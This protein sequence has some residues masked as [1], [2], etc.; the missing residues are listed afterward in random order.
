MTERFLKL[1]Y[2]SRDFLLLKNCCLL[3]TN[4]RLGCLQDIAFEKTGC[5]HSHKN[6]APFLFQ[7][8]SFFNQQNPEVR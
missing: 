5:N 3:F 2:H 4:S 1:I 7:F 6:L 8:S